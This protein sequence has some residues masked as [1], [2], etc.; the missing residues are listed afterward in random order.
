METEELATIATRARERAQNQRIRFV[1]V[2]GPAPS[3]F[4]RFHPRVTVLGGFGDGLTAWLAQ[5]LAYGRDHAP[6]GFAEVDGTRVAFLDLPEGAFRGTCPV[7]GANALAEDLQHLRSASFGDL[8]PE[9][10]A[11]ADSIGDAEHAIEALEG[12]IGAL[13]AEVEAA[14]HQVVQL[15]QR[16][17]PARRTAVTRDRSEDADQLERL[18]EAVVEAQALPRAAHPDAE[19]LARAFE[20][21]DYAVR[22]HRPRVD[23]EEELRKWE[24]VT[25]EARARLA[26]RRANAPRVSA[27]DLA[28]ASRLRESLRDATER[29][30]RVLRRRSDEI[31]AL[32][33]Q[34]QALLHRLGA[35]SYED[36]MLLGTGLGSADA[37]LAIREATNV[38]AAAE[39]RCAE[40]RAELSEPTIE[41]L[42][43][44]R[45]M[46]LRRAEEVL[47]NDPSGDPA[48]TLRGLHIE[49]PALTAAIAALSEKLRSVG[50]RGD[51]D[52]VA[53]A[54]ALISD[55]R[56]L[57]IDQARG[58]IEL[59]ALDAQI[60]D[61]E[62]IVRRG[63]T[64][65]A[66]LTQDIDVRRTE[67]DDLEFDRQ[68]IETRLHA[69]NAENGATVAAITPTIVDRAVASMLRRAD[70]VDA[71]LPIVLEDPFAVLPVELRRGA[72]D[73]LA[74]SA[75]NGTQFILVTGDV[76]AVRWAQTTRDSVAMAWTAEDARGVASA[77]LG[78]TT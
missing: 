29:R 4:L 61:A 64:L 71:T 48:T 39:R 69:A 51:G 25:A 54:Q 66:R 18:L 43:A 3:T 35:R 41:D 65:R 46:L 17:A 77:R 10:Q 67:I 14:E 52:V 62:L 20:A 55:W 8:G 75:V 27:G 6:D 40:L 32:E 53:T 37:D 36:L 44:E 73:A 47:G 60:A 7:V 30:G 68:R 5:A 38:V 72:L 42:R 34:L 11:I 21:L 22:R 16:Q 56:A 78:G 9:L 70:I 50:A 76:M 24:L 58:Q 26:E 12:R 63:R 2:R 49:P 19:P 1:A 59:R 15:Q 74:R 57:R 31:A 23:V 13:T 33:G 28:E 45:D